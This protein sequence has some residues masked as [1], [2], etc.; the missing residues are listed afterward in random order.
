MVTELF[1]RTQERDTKDERLCVVMP[2]YN[3]EMTIGVVLE[4]WHAFLSQLGVDFEIRAY[5]DGSK[6]HSLE[7]MRQVASNLGKRISIRDKGNEGHG[8]TILRGYREAAA[9]GFA[10]VFQIDSD[11]EMGPECFQSLWNARQNCDF[12]LGRRDGRRQPLSRKIV[13]WVSRLSVRFLYGKSVWDVNA[14]Y[15]LM[16]VSACQKFFSSIP[17]ET[18]APNVALSGL[19]ARSRLRSMEILVPQHDRTAGEVSIRR[20]KLLKAAT[21]S[22]IQTANLAS[23]PRKW[24]VSGLI[25]A[26][27]AL[28]LEGVRRLL[29]K[30]IATLYSGTCPIECL[31]R[32]LAGRE[33]HPLSH[34]LNFFGIG[35]Q[36]FALGVFFTCC[37]VFA[38]WSI[39][40]RRNKIGCF[41]SR[42]SGWCFFALLSIV[43]T[44]LKF[45]ASQAGWYYDFESYD[46][47][48][49]IVNAGGNVYAETSRYNYGPIWFMM[50]GMLKSSLGRWFRYGIIAVLSLADVGIGS[51]LWRKRLFVASF[52]FMI[53]N[54]SIHISGCQNQFDNMAVAMA[55]VAL[56][57]LDIPATGK[58]RRRLSYGLGIVLLG[59]SIALKHVFVFFPFWFLFMKASWKKRIA[60]LVVPLAIFVGMFIPYSGLPA[61]LNQH[62]I[63]HIVSDI[64]NSPKEMWRQT[65]TR[66]FRQNVEPLLAPSRGIQKNVFL[67]RS[68]PNGQLYECFLPRGITQRIPSILLWFT[69]MLALGKVSEKRSWFE[70]GLVFVCGLFV[71][72]PAVAPQYYAIPAAAA[73][74]YWQPFGLLYHVIVGTVM[75]FNDN[76]LAASPYWDVVAIILLAGCLS[77][78]L[79]AELKSSFCWLAQAIQHRLSR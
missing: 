42:P 23:S 4:K 43:S 53:S 55:L 16:R 15:R 76:L 61:V 47:V 56:A 49:D 18:F 79:K 35:Y 48:A 59:A 14:P 45:R 30:T 60:S 11:D 9:D 5:N 73:A 19:A 7:V 6:D 75:A 20:W 52:V 44:A 58:K 69:F 72:S 68:F 46:I 21:K 50:L 36:V 1:D 3:E 65:A 40:V 74:V 27:L 39:P 12:L 71:F 28:L 25:L 33:V 10:W 70:K 57:L 13:S 38:L 29:G 17:P 77:Q 63:E 67:Y 24:L 51:L 37:V 66:S 2:V 41:L 26:C 31:N 22:F 78:A 34:Y 54:I 32:V 62:E 8:P 64:A